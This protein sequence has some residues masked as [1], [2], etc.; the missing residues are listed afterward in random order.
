LEGVG[1]VA[2]VPFVMILFEGGSTRLGAEVLSWM[3]S[4]GLGSRPARFA[5][6]M[7]LFLALLAARG[8]VGWLR[9]LTLQRLSLGFVDHWRGRLFSAMAAAEW[10]TLVALRK[11][12]IEHSITS[13]VSRLATGTSQLL[14]SS[15]NLAIIVAQLAVVLTLSPRLLGA[16]VLIFAVSGATALPLLRRAQRY[17]GSLTVAGRNMYQ[18]LSQFLLGLKI[19]KLGNNEARL[20]ARFE[21]SLADLREHFIG[22]VSAQSA[23]RGVFQFVAATIICGALATGLAFGTPPAALAVTLL[24]LARLVGPL[25][26]LTQSLQSYANMLPA[27][28]SLQQTVHDLSRSR[29]VASAAPTSAQERGTGPA[30]LELRDI[31]FRRSPADAWVL[32]GASIAVGAGEF[33]ALTG[34]SGGGK[35]T[36]LDIA[37][38]LL[39]PNRG[40]VL[41]DGQALSTAA[42]KAAW[43]D[44]VAYLTQDP[45]LFD[46]SIRENLLWECPD[47]TE[48][49]M[50]SALGIAGA[51]EFVRGLPS[52]LDQRVGDGGSALSGGQ[53]QRMCLTRALLRRPR[54]LI[55]DEATN[56]L[57]SAGEQKVMDS[58]AALRETLSILA[59]S[60]RVRSFPGPNK[61]YTIE[62]GSIRLSDARR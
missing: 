13:D 11:S 41:V 53:R 60:H 34:V 56:A 24:V 57:D 9:D 8:Y 44:E 48:P 40:Q 10:K 26:Q 43:R 14:L 2:I 20:L 61:V 28:A 38:T 31:H 4:L 52:G 49:E 18:M 12:D 42:A 37:T 62:S 25:L 46:G 19:A 1:I 3:N 5:A 59:V 16:V 33:V 55:L 58:L 17:G 29:A 50:W 15:A 39:E 30:S 23:T 7:A 36:L 54:L 45:F 6:L 27:F 35:T 47:R 51:A 32:T 21:D 22:F